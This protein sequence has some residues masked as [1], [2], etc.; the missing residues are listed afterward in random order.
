MLNNLPPASLETRRHRFL[1]VLLQGT[2]AGILD[3]V[4]RI[5]NTRNGSFLPAWI[6]CASVSQAKRVNLLAPVRCSSVSVRQGWVLRFGLILASSLSMLL[7]AGCNKEES[8]KLAFSH[9]LHVTENGMACA[10]CHGKLN[11]GRFA[12]PTHASCKECHEDWVTAKT[13]DAKTCGM[14]HKIKDLKELSLDKPGKMT[15]Q[16][17]GVFMHSAALT[18][19]CADCHGTLF[20]KKVTRIPEMTR[21]VKLEIRE[22]AHKWGMDCAACHVN[23]DAKTPPPNHS[24]NWTRRHG[25]LGTQPDNVCGVCHRDES[26]RECH[27]VTRP[28]SH[29]NLWRLKTHGMQ[30]AW[31]RARCLVC[32]QQD[33]CDAC[34]AETRPLS[35]N[36]G[37]KQNHCLNCH[38]SKG[39]GSGCTVCHETDIGSHPNP[40]A[41]G[42]RSQHCNNCHAGPQAEQCGVCHEGGASLANHPNPHGAGWKMQHCTSCHPG[43]PDSQQCSV[44]HGGSLAE[45]HVNPHVAGWR[46]Q[47]CNNCHAGSEAAGCGVCH[48]GV[49]SLANHPD[50]HSAGWRERHCFSCHEGTP[51]ADQCAVCHPGG[52][53]TQVHSSFWPVFHNHMNTKNCGF[54]HQP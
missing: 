43:S 23:M 36:A 51:S 32:H 37:W 26:C 33:S 29:N 35:H 49:T 45:G 52:N 5:W 54:C 17:N 2:V 21:K 1:P 16:A 44:C 31:D 42:W 46:S 39:T 8:Y 28:A 24:Q 48:E 53:N 50:P 30:G 10:D 12:V 14:C 15:A 25:E 40:H 27:Q 20:D 41:A 19:R 47:H 13:I 3:S 7:S 22:R 18:N 34:H 38:V 9:N 4:L 6:L 11:E